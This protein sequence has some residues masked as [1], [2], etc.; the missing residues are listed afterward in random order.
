MSFLDDAYMQEFLK[1]H[2]DKVKLFTRLLRENLGVTDE[3]V[4][5]LGDEGEPGFR[6]GPMINT[7]YA[8]A[9]RSM[10]LDVTVVLQQPKLR[11]DMAEPAVIKALEDLPPEGVILLNTSGRIGNLSRLGLSYRTFCKNRHHRFLSS[12]NWSLVPERLFSNVMAAIDIDYESLEKEAVRLQERLNAASTI[13]VTTVA[14]TDL[15][16]DVQGMRALV[17]AGIYHTAGTGGNL[18]AG[19]VYIPPV[20]RGVEGVAVIDGSFRTKDRCIIPKKPI[21][22]TIRK[23]EIVAMSESG[24]LL[25]QTLQWAERRAKFPWGIRRISE[26]GIGLNAQATLIGCTILDEKVRGTVHIANG[27]NKWFGG[28][29][30]AIIHLDHVMKQPTVYVDGEQLDL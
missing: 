18:P 17:N 8:E 30:A 21:R 25:E 3:H 14:G 12:S 9:A 5:I 26:L 24:E 13:R 15:T 27:S 11:G 20:K 7:L 1:T 23:G 6:I 22:M 28:D 29:V 16:F 10:G 2:A 19:E 4:L